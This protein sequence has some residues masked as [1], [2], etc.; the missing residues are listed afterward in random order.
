MAEITARLTSLPSFSALRG[1]SP[2]PQDLV[3]FRGIAG[4]SLQ[5]WIK[6]ML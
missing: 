6:T 2:V 5:R 3:V 4:K 1:D